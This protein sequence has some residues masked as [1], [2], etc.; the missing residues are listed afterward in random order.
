MTAGGELGS[1][2]AVGPSSCSRR[3][4]LWLMAA[5]FVSAGTMHFLFPQVFFPIVP[6]FV[7]WPLVA[8]YLSGA[9]EVLLGLGLLVPP[10]SRPAA[11]GLCLLLVAVFPANVY[12]WLRGLPPAPTWYHPIRLPLQGVLIAWAFWLSRPPAQRSEPSTRD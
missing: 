4:G 8:I 10:L 1:A 3:T 5:L 6:P 2:R 7:P 12:H 9:A 11:A